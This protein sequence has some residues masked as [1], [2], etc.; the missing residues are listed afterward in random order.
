MPTTVETGVWQL[1]PARSTV[2]LRHKTMWGLVTVKGIFKSVSGGGEVLADGTARG[3]L[4][5]DA[6]S[7]D[8]KQAKRD[9]HLRSADF[10]HVDKH[11]EITYTVRRATLGADGTVQVTGDLTVRGNTRPLAFAARADQAGQGAVAVAAEVAVDRADFDL[12]WNQLGMLRGL[13]TVTVALRFTRS[14]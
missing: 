10:F 11:P 1:D 12:N 14:A 7:L 6:A 3:T 9:K 5:L 8:T 4:T 2:T 13:T